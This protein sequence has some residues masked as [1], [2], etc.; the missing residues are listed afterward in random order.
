[1]VR[2]WNLRLQFQLICCLYFMT[3]N[4]A[5]ACS[6]RAFSLNLGLLFGSWDILGAPSSSG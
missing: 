1:M 2:S 3:L 5:L 6:E 4:L